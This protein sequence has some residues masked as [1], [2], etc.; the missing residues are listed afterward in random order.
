MLLQL[1]F[2]SLS[3]LLNNDRAGE[4][5]GQVEE[6]QCPSNRWHQGPRH[7]IRPSWTYQLQNKTTRADIIQNTGVS[8]S[9]LHTE[10]WAKKLLLFYAARSADDLLQSDNQKTHLMVPHQ[11]APTR[12]GAQFHTLS[13]CCLPIFIPG[14]LSILFQVHKLHILYKMPITTWE[15]V[16]LI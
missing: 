8:Q 4:E 16:W 9:L 14:P 15:R 3:R 12:L 1:S 6:D 7:G 13:L 2:E 5:K 10:L 11:V